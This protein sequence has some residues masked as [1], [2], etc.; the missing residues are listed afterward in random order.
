M[1]GIGVL[2]VIIVIISAIVKAVNKGKQQAAQQKKTAAPR[3]TDPE[4]AGRTIPTLPQPQI[5]QPAAPVR[6]ETAQP[7][8]KEPLEAHMHEPVMGQEGMGTE[9]EDC[10]HEYMLTGDSRKN[11][12]S[13]P[14]PN[15]AEDRSRAQ[16]L[17]QGVIFSEILG[18]RNTSKRYGGRRA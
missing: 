17:L 9:G 1:E 11:E 5:P 18:R 6:K 12:N 8:R 7:H 13:V 10:C 15:E 3:R 2:W 14:A 16:A 4:T